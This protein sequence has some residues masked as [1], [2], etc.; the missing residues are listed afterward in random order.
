MSLLV[1]LLLSLLF[2]SNS[3]AL[4]SHLVNPLTAS[5]HLLSLSL[6]LSFGLSGFSGF[7]SLSHTLSLCVCDS[8]S[9]NLETITRVS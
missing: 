5:S 6:S 9:N 4:L 1:V 2:N 8:L 3:R 7:L